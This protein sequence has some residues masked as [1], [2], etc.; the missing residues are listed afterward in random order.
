MK[1]NILFSLLIVSTT[2]LFV[3]CNTPDSAI[4]TDG[5]SKITIDVNK[6]VDNV[7]GFFEGLV[8]KVN[9]PTK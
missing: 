7:D 6:A 3:G 1:K 9:N 5:N 4:Q 8:D 2:L